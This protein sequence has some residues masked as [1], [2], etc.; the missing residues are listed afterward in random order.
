MN[1]PQTMAA[2]K[3]IHASIIMEATHADVNLDINL[4]L[5]KFIHQH[6]CT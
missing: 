4:I 2:V 3:S 1:V 6:Y 5:R